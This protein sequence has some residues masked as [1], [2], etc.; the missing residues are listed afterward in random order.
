MKRWRFFFLFLTLYYQHNTLLHE[1]WEELFAVL[2]KPIDR[3][4][5]ANCFLSKKLNDLKANV[6]TNTTD[7]IHALNFT[8]KNY[9]DPNENEN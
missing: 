4:L 3:A 2:H 1:L 6:T 5:L 8:D 9:I 7:L